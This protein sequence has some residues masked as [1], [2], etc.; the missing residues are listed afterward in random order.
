MDCA[1]CPAHIAFTNDDDELRSKT[2]EEWSKMFDGSFNAEDIN[3]A[4]CIVTDGI[5]VGYCDEC[6]V[7]LCG[8]QKSIA[9]CAHCSEYPCEKL[10]RLFEIVAPGAKE[11]LDEIR[12]SL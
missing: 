5:H 7:R 6:A 1:Q 8:I 3:C 10:T 9:T 11:T 4:G 2:A 12:A